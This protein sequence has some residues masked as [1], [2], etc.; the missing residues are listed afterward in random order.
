MPPGTQSG[1]VFRV[2]GRGMPD[3]R[4][5][6][7]GDLHVQTYIEVPKK[8]TP[9]QDALL[10]QLADLEQSEVSPHRKSFLERLKEYFASSEAAGSAT[11]ER[12]TKE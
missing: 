11:K 1:D 10:R 12:V 3:P 8:V 2:R 4:G 6:S 7:A 5:G 9:R